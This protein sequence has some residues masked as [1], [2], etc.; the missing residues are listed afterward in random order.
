MWTKDLRNTHEMILPFGRQ[1]NQE[2]LVGRVRGV[3][4]DQAGILSALSWLGTSD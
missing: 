2:S 3:L 4:G 1:A